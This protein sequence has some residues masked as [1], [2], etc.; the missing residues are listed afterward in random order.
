MKSP[1]LDIRTVDDKQIEIRTRDNAFF[2]FPLSD[3]EQLPIEN[4]S[5]EEIAKY[6]TDRL[7]EKI[8]KQSLVEAGVTDVAIGIME[9]PGQEASYNLKLN[10]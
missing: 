8:G 4:T 9:T 2:S 6:L 1:H 7:V 10:H 3:V 5:V